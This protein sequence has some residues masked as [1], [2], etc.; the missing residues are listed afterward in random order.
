RWTVLY[1]EGLPIVIGEE[2]F[3]VDRHRRRGKAFP[4]RDAEPA[5]P[6]GAAGCRVKGRDDAG[7][8][9][10]G[11]ETLAIEDRRGHEWRAARC[12]PREMTPG[13]VALA[14]GPDRQRRADAS[15]R[16][17]HQPVADDRC[18]N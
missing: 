17:K 12:T 8:V 18:R 13:N 11:V 15:R 4:P 5:L 6:E 16:T 2:N 1:N 14:A 9:V 10:D 7:H 3:S